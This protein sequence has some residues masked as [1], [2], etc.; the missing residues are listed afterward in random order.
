MIRSRFLYLAFQSKTIAT[1][2]NSNMSQYIINCKTKKAR[3]KK[4]TEPVMLLRS[5]C[6]ENIGD[7]FSCCCLA[8]INEIVHMDLF[9]ILFA[10]V[11]SIG[12]LRKCLEQV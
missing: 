8:A 3:E 5:K 6:V 7:L 11:L 10:G 2:I 9:G 1:E 4:C 12:F